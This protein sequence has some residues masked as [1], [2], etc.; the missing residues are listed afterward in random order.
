MSLADVLGSIETLPHRFEP[1][2]D[3]VKAR[4]RLNVANVSR[5][6][7]I[8]GT[9]CKVEK[10]AGEPDAEISTDALT[11]H[12]ME[13]G[14]LSGIEAFG[15]RRLSMRGSIEQAL[16]FEPMFTRPEGGFAYRLEKI[17]TAGGRISAL[18]AGDAAADPLILI[19]GLGA[20]KAS[21]LTV[22]PQLASTH[23]VIAVDLPGHGASDK[24]LGRYDA[25][26]FAA[27]MNGLL[28]ALD[29]D[30]AYIVGNSMGGRI[31]ME[32]GMEHPERVKAVACLCPA[33]AFSRRP[34]LALVR[35]LRPEMGM[36]ASRLPRNRML[37]QLKQLF[38]DPGCLE[39]AWYEAAIDDFLTV[40]KS[41]RARLAFF[42]SLRNIYL[43]EPEGERGFWSRLAAMGTPALFVYGKRD[44][45][46]SHHFARKVLRTLPGAEVVVWSD[47]G[48]VPQIEFPDRT[49]GLL[50][51]FFARSAVNLVS[52]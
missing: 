42:A 18:I 45:I 30:S 27:R 46:I 41:P 8:D 19:H 39:D 20:T 13:G 33:A 25:A 4:F 23:R 11:W 22:V 47:C 1:P 15:A 51:G 5:D 35:W 14:K 40:W 17:K 48:H 7:V 12:E 9:K 6:V 31:A 26:W 52:A 32:L 49:A 34:A 16:H 28:D 38:A 44:L 50:S 10:P 43:D 2:L 37:P 24:P 29:I 21:W 3:P 36:L